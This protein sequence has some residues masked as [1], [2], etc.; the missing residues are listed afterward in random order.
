MNRHQDLPLGIDSDSDPDILG[1]PVRKPMK[2]PVADDT[3]PK[4]PSGIQR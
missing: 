4:I 2:S 1:C 3:N